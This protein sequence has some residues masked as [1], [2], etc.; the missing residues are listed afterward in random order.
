MSQPKI[1]CVHCINWI[2]PKADYNNAGEFT[3]AKC[4]VE[5][6]CPTYVKRS[7][8]K[9]KNLSRKSND[10]KRELKN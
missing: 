7:K 5:E 2:P 9:L 3:D 10:M 8:M 6:C 4:K 1:A